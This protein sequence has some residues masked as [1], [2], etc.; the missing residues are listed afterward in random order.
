[1]NKILKI[2]LSIDFDYFCFENPIWDFGHGEVNALFKSS[3]LWAAR[4]LHV[5]LNNEVTL[6]KADFNPADIIKELK[7]KGLNII[8]GAKMGM[9]DSHKYAYDFFNKYS[10]NI[11]A[12][13]NCDAHH[14]CWPY[15]PKNKPDCGNW[16]TAL[17]KPVKWIIPKWKN[18]EADEAP[19]IAIDKY[20]WDAFQIDIPN[21]VTA[22]FIC[23][24]S[25]WVPPHLDAAYSEFAGIMAENFYPVV[26]EPVSPREML[27][28]S[29][30]AKERDKLTVK[31]NSKLLNQ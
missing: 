20:T 3:A 14:D 2:G 27:N 16:L 9:A 5:D 19:S 8:D 15:D 7:L 1:M 18:L 30:L 23:R 31:F 11:D 12:I 4:Y 10:N 28:Y 17:G 29:A 24:S 25:A 6:D 21:I 26:L 13:V 22:A